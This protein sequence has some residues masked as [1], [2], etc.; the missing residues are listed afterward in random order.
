MQTNAGACSGNRV[1]YIR[2]DIDTIT[3]MEQGVPRLLALG[4]ELGVNFSFFVNFGRSI[5][6]RLIIFRKPAKAYQNVKGT[7]SKLGAIQK[8]GLK[9]V[10]RTALFNPK[11]GAKM[12]GTLENAV[13]QGHEIGLHGGN[14]HATWQQTALEVSEEKIGQWLDS[15]LPIYRKLVLSGGGFASPGFVHPAALEKLLIERG[16]SYFSDEMADA[17][18]TIDGNQHM[19]R[20]PVTGHALGVPIIESM[21]ASGCDDDMIIE[22]LDRWV[23]TPGL[24]TFYAHPVWEGYR[25]LE[26]FRIFL[27]RLLDSGY[28]IAPYREAMD[29][30]SLTGSNKHEM[31]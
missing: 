1:V 23:S 9:D 3:C 28:A 5:D 2:F 13:L 21:R 8:L 12:I 18:G 14:N 31:G 24:K 20:I 11:V 22:L 7:C 27:N 26:L 4:E 10:L 19:K 30:K 25:D 16:F 15:V 6:P 17:E 29:L